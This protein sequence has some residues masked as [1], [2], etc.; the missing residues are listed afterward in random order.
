M[1]FGQNAKTETL[2][3]TQR[4]RRGNNGGV[5]RGLRKASAAE[6]DVLDRI[7]QRI[8]PNGLKT[9]RLPHES[10]WLAGMQYY[11]G[12]QHYGLVDGHFIDTPPPDDDEHEVLYKANFAKLHIL[13]ALAKVDGIQPVFGVAPKSESQRQREIAAIS[14]RVRRHQLEYMDWDAKYNS[15]GLWAAI[16]GSGFGKI[17]WDSTAGAPQRVYYNDPVEK[18]PIPPE[19][20]SDEEKRQM[21]ALG[22]F[23]DFKEGEVELS[24][25][26]PFGAYHDWSARD[27]GIKTCQW[28]ADAQYTDI[29]LIAERWGV[30]PADIQPDEGSR[31]LQNY[32]EAIAFM[33]SNTG[34]TP[35]S[36]VTPTEKIA[37]RALYVDMYDRPNRMWPKGRRTVYAGG[38]ILYDG[39]N[40]YI[41]DETGYAHL[42]YFKRDWA[43]HPG[44]FWGTSLMED[45]M[46]PQFY[47]NRMR[48]LML[49]FA[50]V[51]G[52]A[53]TF[54]QKGAGLDTTNMVARTGGIYEIENP[55]RN[56]KVGADPRMPTE[57]AGML[58]VCESDMNKIAAQS[59]MDGS[60]LPQQ[61]RSGA[62][63]RTMLNERSVGLNVPIKSSQRAVR[64]AGRISLAIGKMHY[65]TD[66]VMQYIGESGNEFVVETFT[67]ADLNNDVRIVVS[68]S[69]EDS[70]DAQR[71]DVLDS[72]MVGALNPAEN[73]ED[74]MLFLSAMK[75]GTYD[76][77]LT[78]KTQAKRNQEREIELM[79]VDPDRYG[80]TYPVAEFEDH[81]AEARVLVSYMYSAE[82]KSLPPGTQAV[83]MR[84]WKLH[85]MH[86]EQQRQ[87]VMQ[88][89]EA[90]KGAPGA[91][92][93]PSQPRR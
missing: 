8:A 71:Q 4:A 11:S 82:F 66:R 31:G 76:E 35:L 27:G 41:G 54:V 92:G 65:K 49:S 46:A 34:Y 1:A 75:F 73:E 6:L 86:L 68:S 14:E 83:I 55:D 90:A 58:G 21:D 5:Y 85:M 44:R 30:D 84:H 23:E 17:W 19:M 25:V 33:S 22:L 79:K 10:L 40:P 59:E 36:Y 26:V 88:E 81:A 77:I 43:P 87:Q 42:P 69:I 15:I 37:K 7:N 45:L 72:V 2:I 67:G 91:K 52:H 13:R 63:I 62:A 39:D 56:V 70:P 18:R 24:L 16:C 29:D 32:E 48:E 20:M 93:K 64:D 50:E 60:K 9:E 80:V 28:F 74:R 57:V 61:M 38:L 89:V 47:T 3:Q 53:P 51:H 12:R 78:V